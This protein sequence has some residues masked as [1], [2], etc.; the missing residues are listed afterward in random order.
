[1]LPGIK[2]CTSPAPDSR[3][4]VGFFLHSGLVLVY[5]G[6]Y[7]KNIIDLGGLTNIYFSSFWRLIPFLE[8]ACFVCP[9][10][11]EGTRDLSRFLLLGC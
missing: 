1:M 8:K 7:N 5:L 2:I 3:L 6:R 9:H 10:M 4:L 11:V